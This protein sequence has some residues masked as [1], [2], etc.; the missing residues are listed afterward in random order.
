MSE[1]KV[2][3]LDFILCIKTGILSRVF[4][5]VAL[6]I[7]LIP[8]AIVIITDVPFSSSSSKTFICTALG[9]IIMGKLLTLLKKNKGDKS[10][11]VD[12]GV[13]IGIL[14]AFISRVLK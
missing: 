7:F 10:I 11:P 14:I 5:F 4:Y 6:L 13:I 3:K 2:N 8:A 9:F 12:I 1:I